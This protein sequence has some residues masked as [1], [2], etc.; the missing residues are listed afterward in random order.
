MRVNAIANAAS[1]ELRAGGGV[2]GAICRA[3]GPKLERERRRL[4]GCKVD[5][6][7]LA[8]YRL[9]APYVIQALSAVWQGGRH[10]K[11]ELLARCYRSSLDLTSRHG[12]RKVAFP[13]VSTGVYGFPRELAAAIAV[14]AVAEDLAGK[15]DRTVIFCCFGDGSVAPHQAAP[16][17][18]A[19]AQ[20]AGRPVD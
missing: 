13:V 20:E 18:L 2:C 4:G 15:P 12:L 17:G 7:K 8:G 5:A 16:A 10:G 19:G 1:S 14:G 9:P 6:A 3:A 11:A